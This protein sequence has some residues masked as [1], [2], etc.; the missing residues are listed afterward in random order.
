M[1]FTGAFDGF[2]CDYLNKAILLTTS[3]DS[4]EVRIDTNRASR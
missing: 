1:T 3:Q 2:T 4:A